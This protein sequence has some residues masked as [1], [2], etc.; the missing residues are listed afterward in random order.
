MSGAAPALARNLS[1]I[2]RMA[3]PGDYNR[4]M[5]IRSFQ[6]LDDVVAGLAEREERFRAANDRRCIFLTL[7][8]I[9]S[10]EMRSRVRRR[11]FHDNTWVESYAVA[12]AN[13][14][15]Q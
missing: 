15:R 12:F 2:P 13:Y 1:A 5:L 9:V 10:T 4:A 7:Y 3:I 11:A 14:Y 8:G 6:T